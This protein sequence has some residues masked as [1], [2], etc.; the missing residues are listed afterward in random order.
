MSTSEAKFDTFNAKHRTPK[1]IAETFVN[2]ASILARL[3]SKN[4]VVLTGPRGSGKTT[5]LKMLTITGLA[6]WKGEQAASFKNDVDFVS[7]FVPADRSWHGQIKEITRQIA[8]ESTSELLGSATFTTHIFKAII[9]SFMDWQSPEAASDDLISRVVP[10][11]PYES[12]RNIVAK[13]SNEWMLE[14]EAFTFFELNEAL[15][16][17]LGKIGLLKNKARRFGVDFLSDDQYDFLHLS[18]REGIKRAY[19]LHNEASGLPDRRWF[20]MFDELEVAPSDIQQQ[21]LQDLRGA[22]EDQQ[23]VYK[24]ALAPYNRNFVTKDPDTDASDRNDY[25]HIDLTFPRKKNAIDFSRRLCERIAESA[26]V[27]TNLQEIFGISPFEFDDS[28]AASLAEATSTYNADAPLG[29]VFIS[30]AKKDPSFA[31]YL[32]RK[33]IDF[34]KVEQMSEVELASSLRKVRNIVIIRDYFTRSSRSGLVSESLSARSRKTYQLYSGM[35]SIL[36]LSEGNPRSL[37]NLI[38]PLFL[39]RRIQEIPPSE[40]SKVQADEIEKS[41]R[42]MRSLLKAIPSRDRKSETVLG[43]MDRIGA[44]FYAGVISSKFREQPPLSFRVDHGQPPDVL[45]C[46]GKAVNVGA[47]I[48]VPDHGSEEVISTIIGRRFRLNYLLSAYYKLPLSLDR[49]LSLSE[50]LDT[51]KSLNQGKLDV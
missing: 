19:S 12:E 4:H 1:E 26:G 20:I 47:L 48:Y 25:H 24:L 3:V 10:N 43:L 42:V 9:K 33:N 50:L 45:A 30:L 15:A 7:I 18:Y 6:N 38:N 34:D 51:G 41:I 14:P 29:K 17:R 46:I 11:I 37:I 13:L 32:A 8:D 36:T 35:P 16:K 21:L 49:E 40:K 27:T 22:P 23:I 2:P 31:S 39:E 44:G 5:L 28:D